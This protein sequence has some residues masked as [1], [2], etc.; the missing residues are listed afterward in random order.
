MR[1]RFLAPEVIQTSAMDCGPAALKSLLEGYGINVSYGRLREAAQTEV[2]GTSIDVLEDLAVRLGLDATQ[3]MLPF[4]HLAV[5][6][7]FPALLVTKDP[8]GALHFIV[9]WRRIG[10]YFQIMDP[11]RGRLWADITT[12]RQITFKHGMPVPASQ[13][14][15]WVG[16]V[17]SHQAFAARFARIGV[18]KSGAGLL[19][20]ARTDP[21]WRSFGALDAALR[22]TASLVSE[23]VVK[24]GHAANSL[25]AALFDEALRDLVAG[26]FDSGEPVVPRC[27]WSAAPTAT[28]EHVKLT[29]AVLVR[30]FGVR[31]ERT[32]ARLP[33]DVRAALRER[34]PQPLRHLGS[35]LREDGV[36][37]PGLL[38]MSLVAATLGGALE[39][40]LLRA[41][42]DVGRHL[43]IAEQRLA[44]FGVLAALFAVLLVLDVSL[45]G[46]ALRMG[47]RLETRLRVAFLRKIPRLHDRYFQSRPMSDM[48]HRAH[49]I[50]PIRE[51]PQLGGRLLRSTMDL[52]VAAAGLVWIDA[53]SWPLVLL[54]VVVSTVGPWFAQQTMAERD[55]RARSFDG[56]LTRFYLDGLLGLLPARAHGAESAVRRQH[57][58]VMMEWSRASLD[59]IRASTFIDALQQIA[60]SLLVVFLVFA[61][62]THEPEPAAVLLFVYWALNVPVLGQEITR[63][64]LLYPSMR[65]RLLRLV[66]PLD[67]VEEPEAN[68]GSQPGGRARS[69]VAEAYIVFRNVSVRAAGHTILEDVDLAIPSGAHVAI[70]GASGAGKSSLVALLLGWHRP[71]SG[72]VSVNGLPLRGDHLKQVRRQ[73]AWV[74]AAIHLWNR[75]LLANLEYGAVSNGERRV[76]TVLEDA[77]LLSLLERLPDGLQTNLGEGGALVAGGEGQRVR[78]G[79]AMMRKPQLVILDEAFR[80]LARERRRALLGRARERWK[81]ATLLCATHDVMDTRD[82][83][84]VIVLVDGRVCEQG[85]PR[86]LCKRA[87]SRYAAMLLAEENVQR[88]MWNESAWRRVTVR[89]GQLMDGSPEAAEETE[90]RL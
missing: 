48:A 66:E 7:P 45:S 5:G 50:H 64:A 33:A 30:I 42:I 17:E 73:T 47:R 82:F 79:R 78:L 85:P 90:V 32:D 71:A 68:N 23:K 41:A 38:L 31:P 83:D 53:R 12:L 56:S 86:A 8:V 26:H 46:G 77:D 24:R 51:L 76:G 55:L 28:P 3:T 63:T 37:A 40:L 19:E 87:D 34:P 52:L 25:L 74:D 2:D 44:G 39:V 59:R 62:L 21:S 43:N 20:R 80:G 54:A 70:V 75:S 36:L 6:A 10:R 22:M 4:E 15:T 88:R 35:I 16:S 57:A 18:R 9:V 69:G 27:Y 67:A 49:A 61:Y 11:G 1:R 60:G 89:N 29:G 65:N 84:H 58:R 14:R 81:D 13:W 72:S